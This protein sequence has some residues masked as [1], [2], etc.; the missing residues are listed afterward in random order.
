MLPKR[1]RKFSLM[2]LIALAGL[3]LAVSLPVLSSTAIHAAPVSHVSTIVVQPGDTLWA[4][5]SRHTANGDDVQANIERIV[6][7]NKIDRAVGLQIGQ[8]VRIPD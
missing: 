2:P 6:A 7:I 1:K 8:K 3:S 4:L 5:A